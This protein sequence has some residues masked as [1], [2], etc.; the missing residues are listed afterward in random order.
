MLGY[1]ENAAQ[2][3]A[4]GIDYGHVDRRSRGRGGDRLPL[5]SPTAT[6][7]RR[8]STAREGCSRPCPPAG[9]WSTLSTSAP[10]STTRI[11]AAFAE[12]SVEFV[13]CGISGGAA[14][15]EK[16]VLSLMVGGAGGGAL[17]YHADPR[18]LQHACLPH[19]AFGIGPRSEAAEQFS[20]R[21][22][23][24]RD[25]RGDGC[26]QAVRSRSGPVPRCRLQPLERRQLRDADPVPAD[27]RG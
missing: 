10:S 21:D 11:H 14:A 18:H 26:R 6:S 20:Q 1:D 8:S 24:R 19:G 22:Q 17:S 25:C 4:W 3:N 23:S 2:L 13:D 9:S 16:G 12:R 5:R 15:A 27:H 7:S